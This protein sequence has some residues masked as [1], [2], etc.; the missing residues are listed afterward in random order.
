ML[1]RAP[2]V[3]ALRLA[4]SSFTFFV[5]APVERKLLRRRTHADALLVVEAEASGG[6]AHGES[7]VSRDVTS[8]S[9]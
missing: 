8:L 5:R 2:E 9:K 6:A 7:N 4:A 3:R 1:E